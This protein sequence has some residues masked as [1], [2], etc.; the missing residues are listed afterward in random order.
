MT[1]RDC[2][3]DPVAVPEGEPVAVR[4]P[5]PDSVWLGLCVTERDEVTL[6]VREPVGETDWLG[7]AVSD[8]GHS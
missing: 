8:A 6:G 5:V 3:C 2:V 4:V 1:D 7:D